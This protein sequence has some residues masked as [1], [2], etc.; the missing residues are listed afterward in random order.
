MGCLAGW[1]AGLFFVC[2][3]AAA[4]LLAAHMLPP[5]AARQRPPCPALPCLPAASVCR[6]QAAQILFTDIDLGRSSGGFKSGG[7]ATS[8]PNSGAW[9]TFFNIRSSGRRGGHPLPDNNA[10]D[11]GDCSYGP[12]L[13][14][15]GVRFE[16]ARRLCKSWVY[17]PAAVTPTNLFEAQLKLRR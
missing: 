14:F 4:G 7:P 2:V 16:D 17:E 10:G 11:P 8:G 5:A 12:N 13:N 1:L 15:I 3:S 6:A 9:T